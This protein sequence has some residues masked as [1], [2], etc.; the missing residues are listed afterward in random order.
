MRR[1]IASAAVETESCAL[2]CASS[3]R[4]ARQERE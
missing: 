3:P 1:N 4:R 2:A